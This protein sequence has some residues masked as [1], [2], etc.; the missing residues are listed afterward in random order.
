MGGLYNDLRASLQKQVDLVTTD[1]LSQ[2]DVQQR[3]PWIA[4]NLQRERLMIYARA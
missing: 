4:E 2:R 3:T 1:G